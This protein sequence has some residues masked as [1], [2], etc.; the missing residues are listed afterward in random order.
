MH[1]LSENMTL[2][3][4]K[5][6]L[7]S[8]CGVVVFGLLS[9][10]TGDV[11][12]ERGMKALRPLVVTAVPPNVVLEQLIGDSLLGRSGKL[13]ARFVPR[14]MVLSYPDIASTQGA[15][16]GIIAV[17]ITGGQGVF[18]FV[19]LVP[20]GE[21]YGDRVGSYV[22]GFWPG[23]LRTV[24]DEDYANPRGFIEVTPDNELTRVSEHFTLRDFI[25]KD[26]QKGWPRYVVLQEPLLDKLELVIADL[27]LRG[28]PVEHVRVMSGFRTPYHNLYGVGSEG[29]AR[30][31]RHQYGDAADIIID[32]NRDGRMDDLNRD[33]RVDTRDLD[34]VLAAVERVER[35]WPELVGG[36]GSYSAMGPS[37]PFAHIDV[38]GYRARWDNNTRRTAAAV[39]GGAAPSRQTVQPGQAV[40]VSRCNASAEFAV[41][42]GGK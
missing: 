15:N 26:S 27:K 6:Y 42:C 28:I 29:G 34:L 18:N 40:K 3:T 32:N 23:E 8:A 24:R 19:S 12:H 36:L 14:P 17:N 20:F 37:G 4:R 5:L 22:V 35:V 11:G 2:P 9:F 33:R 1:T 31:S 39:A 41:L 21:K 10:A 25:T 16:P 38:R 13:R 30:D 7:F